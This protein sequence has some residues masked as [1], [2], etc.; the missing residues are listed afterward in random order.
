MSA[1]D[2][3]DEANAAIGAAISTGSLHREF[4]SLLSEIQY[5]L[6]DHADGGAPS[7]DRLRF[8]LRRHGVEPP[9]GFPVLGGYSAAAGLLKLAA[10]IS[11]RAARQTSS[12]YLR[13]LPDVLLVIAFHTEQE[14]SARVP[15]GIC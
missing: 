5:E 11:R 6:L 9:H 3:V 12:E 2:A 7:T 10:A 15:F 4:R 8:A 13:V 14:E 1:R